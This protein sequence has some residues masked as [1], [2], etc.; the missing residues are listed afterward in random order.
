MGV[1]WDVDIGLL[2]E[3][4]TRASEKEQVNVVMRALSARS[5]ACGIHSA[6]RV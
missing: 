2:K 6:P 5:A 3:E 4:G 1:D